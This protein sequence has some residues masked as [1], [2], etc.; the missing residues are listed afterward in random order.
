MRRIYWD[1]A[2]KAA[3]FKIK[4]ARERTVS[5]HNSAAINRESVPDRPMYVSP[6]KIVQDCTIERKTR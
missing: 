4:L 6:A 2:R 3:D 1:A 5:L